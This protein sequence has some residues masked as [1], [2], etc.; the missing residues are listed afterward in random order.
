MWLSRHALQRRLPARV[1]EQY[2]RLHDSVFQCLRRPGSF[3]VISAVIW[4]GEGLRLLL[5]ARSLG[6]DIS[7]ATALFVALMGS[8]LTTLPFTPAG[9]G[10]VEGATIAVLVKVIGMDPSLAGSIAI[11][12]RVV[13]YWSLVLVGL[14]LYLYRL[15]R[16]ARTSA[17]LQPDSPAP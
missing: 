13:G 10:L 16:E 8:L 14:I 4:L 17:L 2:G 5:V 1:Q 9:L 12:D 11:L 7:L 15:R 3:L 6:A